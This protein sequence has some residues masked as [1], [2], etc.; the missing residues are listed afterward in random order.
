MLGHYDRSR[1]LHLFLRPF[2]SFPLLAFG[3]RNRP[4]VLMEGNSAHLRVGD[5]LPPASQ[6]ERPGFP[7]DKQAVLRSPSLVDPGANMREYN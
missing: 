7:T 2:S 3:H 6:A 4:F 1:R 5:L